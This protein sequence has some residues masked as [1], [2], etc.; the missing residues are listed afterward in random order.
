MRFI[1]AMIGF[2][3]LVEAHSVQASG[4]FTSITLYALALDV[5]EAVSWYIKK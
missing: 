1:I 5:V 3:Y 2:T 4:L